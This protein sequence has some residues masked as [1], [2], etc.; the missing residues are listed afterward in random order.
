M[1]HSLENPALDQL[2]REARTRNGW[3]EETLPESALHEIYDPKAD[4]WSTAAPMPTG[5]SSSAYA[6]YR[7]LL[8]FAGGECRTPNIAHGTFDENEAYDL[9]A[10]KWRKLAALP[11]GRHGF[12]AAA[13][14][15]ALYFV[16]GSTECGSGGRLN[17]NLA[18][19]LP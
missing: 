5:R 18:F 14:G 4:K 10:G 19:T 11:A 6:E 2:F 17:D 1:S 7:G 16:G 8:F 9:K 13:V 3:V 15:N 12:A